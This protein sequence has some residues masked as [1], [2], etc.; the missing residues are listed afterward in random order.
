MSPKRTR[1]CTRRSPTPGTVTALFG[2]L[3]WTIAWPH[4]LSTRSQTGRRWDG[5]AVLSLVPESAD[6]PSEL[7]ELL[8][9]GSVQCF[10]LGDEAVHVLLPDGSAVVWR[11]GQLV[12]LSPP[13]P[14]EPPAPW[15]PELTAQTLFPG[16][17]MVVP[18]RSCAALAVSPDG[19]LVAW[20]K[21]LVAAHP[22]RRMDVGHHV[23]FLARLYVLMK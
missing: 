7:I 19:T 16:G 13:Q 15:S 20:D 10:N 21:A 1:T 11:D 12:R 9:D 18:W 4:T 14:A 6:A 17:C 5:G 8:P 2:E 22:Q 3:R 23:G